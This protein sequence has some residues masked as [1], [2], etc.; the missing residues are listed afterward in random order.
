MS[1][2]LIV[3]CPAR[4]KYRTRK[5][6][7]FWVESLIINS[8]EEL[9]F[10]RSQFQYYLGSFYIFWILTLY[11]IHDSQIF[12]PFSR[13]SFHFVDAFLWCAETLFLFLFP[14]PEETYPKKYCQ[15]WCQKVYCLFSSFFCIFFLTMK[16]VGFW[17]PN[18][19]LN[20]STL[21]WMHRANHSGKSQCT[22]YCLFSPENF[23]VCHFTF[24]ALVHFE[25]I[26]YMM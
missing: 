15:D 17:F 21:Q 3:L 16:L 12:L 1:P 6:I 9:C 10:W 7:Q 23:T 18:Q 2:F 22:M 20:P 8:A 13:L 14:L 5:G 24:K 11:Q 4:N 19:G 25:L 26:F